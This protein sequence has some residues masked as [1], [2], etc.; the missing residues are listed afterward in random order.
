MDTTKIEQMETNNINPL[1]GPFVQAMMS[2]Q[3]TDAKTYFQ[4][5]MCRNIKDRLDEKKMEVAKRISDKI[6]G[7]ASE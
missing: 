5:L 7:I 1:I 3:A 4:T 2:G 6:K